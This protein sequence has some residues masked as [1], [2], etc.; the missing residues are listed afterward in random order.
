M[1]FLDDVLI[2][3]TNPQDHANHLKKVLGKLREHQLFAKA[4]NYEILKTSI[5][6]SVNKYAEEE[7]LRQRQN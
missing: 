2:Y 1:V 3:S 4:S 7:L 5:E 6:F